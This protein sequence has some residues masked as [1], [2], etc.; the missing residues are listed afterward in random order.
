MSDDALS[1]EKGTDLDS[2][3][4]NAL[5]DQDLVSRGLHGDGVDVQARVERGQDDVGVVPLDG[6]QVGGSSPG[7]N[8]E[9]HL[10]TQ[11]LK[12]KIKV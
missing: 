10:V 5:L 8:T 1:S 4:V 2:V 9:A 6:E 12:V 7:W 11:N 3:V